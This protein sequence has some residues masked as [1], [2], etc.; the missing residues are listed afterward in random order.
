MFWPGIRSLS[1]RIVRRS[2][3]AR[4]GRSIGSPAMW[5]ECLS[6]EQWDYSWWRRLGCCDGGAGRAIAEARDRREIVHSLQWCAEAHPTR[7][8][9]PPC[10][11]FLFLLDFFFDVFHGV[12]DVFA[13]HQ[14]EL[15]EREQG[16][17]LLGHFFVGAPGGIETLAVDLHADLEA[18]A[19]IRALFVEQLIDGGGVHALL[20][21]LLEHGFV[22]LLM[23]IASDELD[24]GG[25][26]A[27]HVDFDG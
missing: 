2:P 18:L 21:V 11:S 24:L 20:G 12:V 17:F 25:H 13:V 27:E 6:R 3:T 23:G 1:T 15:F 26:G 19:V 22:I 14:A 4:R 9:R 8:L 5:K 16:G 10:G 7:N